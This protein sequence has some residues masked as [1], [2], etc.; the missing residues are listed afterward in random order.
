MHNMK[1]LPYNQLFPNEPV[2]LSQENLKWFCDV[3]NNQQ[4]DFFASENYQKFIGLVISAVKDRYPDDFCAPSAVSFPGGIFDPPVTL[5]F[6]DGL[7]IHVQG[8]WRPNWNSVLL[9]FSKGVELIIDRYWQFESLFETGRFA[10]KG[11]GELYE[12]FKGWPEELLERLSELLELDN[13]YAD[14]YC[15]SAKSVANLLV[16]SAAQIYITV[17]KLIQVADEIEAEFDGAIEAISLY[18]S[19]LMTTQEVCFAILNNEETEQAASIKGFI[20]EYEKA[21][22]ETPDKISEALKNALS[23]AN[24]PVI[25]CLEGLR[26]DFAVVQRRAME[27]NEII[28]GIKEYLRP[29]TNVM[30][31]KKYKPSTSSSRIKRDGS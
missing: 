5:E 7:V 8:L 22:K 4:I 12:R 13:D 18:A 10:E 29:N 2:T 16:S 9:T 15:F 3:I 24:L 30:P 11:G 6:L 14:D 23:F 21:I 1:I 17:P 28:A 31:L 20:V 25:P 19:M 27:T 26:E